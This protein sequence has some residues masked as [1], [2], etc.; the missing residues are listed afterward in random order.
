MLY[1]TLKAVDSTLVRALVPSLK[2]L[3]K[4]QSRPT[5][6]TSRLYILELQ[7]YQDTRLEKRL[8]FGT[9][10]LE[11]NDYIPF[12]AQDYPHD[13]SQDQCPKPPNR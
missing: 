10:C 7:M 11:A 6:S 3:T 9:A 1:E 2:S 13:S 12:C 8:Y 4:W 5:G